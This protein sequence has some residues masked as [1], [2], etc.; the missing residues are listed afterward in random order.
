MWRCQEVGVPEIRPVLE[1]VTSR[2]DAPVP[3]PPAPPVPPVP[4]AP[5]P[6][7]ALVPLGVPS[8]VGPS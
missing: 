7:N 5:P 4:V 6:V 2:P 1:I 3:A 8:P